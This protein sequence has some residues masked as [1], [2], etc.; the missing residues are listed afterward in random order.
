[1]K[2]PENFLFGTATSA[3]QIEGGWNAD[4]KGMSIWD[5]FSHQPGRIHGQQNG[6]TACNSYHD[7][8]RDI[9]IMQALN[10]DAYRF[11]ISWPRVLPS[12]RSPVNEKGLEYY[13]RLV[14]ALLEKDVQPF[15]TLFHW[16]MPQNLYEE[17]DGFVSRDCVAIFADY[18]EI[19]AK[20]LGDRV[21]HWITLNE[22]WEHAALGHLL[23][24]H[25]PGVRN[26]WK[27][28]KVAHHQL[29][30]HGL[31]VERIRSYSP[32][33]EVGITLSYTQVQPETNQPRDIWAAR[34][35][36]QFM[37][38]FFLDGV[39][40]GE[41]PQEFWQRVSLFQPKVLQGDMDVISRSLDFV[42]LNY[43]SREFARYA[44][45]IPFFNFWISG[46]ESAEKAFMKEGVQYTSMGWEVYPQGIYDLLIRFKNDYN[47]HPVYI[48]ENG[49]AFDDE[50]INESVPDALR[51]DFLQKHLEKISQA[52]QEGVD[53]RGY[54]IWSLLDNFEWAEGYF[55]R[56]GLVYV[57]HH[58]Q[59]RSIKDSGY[60]IGNLIKELR[61]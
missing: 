26:P 41:Y 46:S 25:A 20:R 40:K 21:K 16:D 56:F 44:W 50:I 2:F 53:L 47:N 3:Y 29:L 18:A 48:T 36:D 14:D 38:K 1:M 34:M 7:F 23:G 45:Y 52:Y 43:Y 58:T 42:G 57:D 35:G 9:E 32:K 22:P 10:L 61:G 4:G 49:A 31:A 8:Y 12:G 11:S 17:M 54:L 15:L 27:Y 55:K 30:A 13:D 24:M 6:D 28:F 19:M 33:S 51:I 59:K 37:N 5:V 39:L 60:W